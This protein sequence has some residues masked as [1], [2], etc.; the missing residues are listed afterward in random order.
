MAKLR[1]LKLSYHN[2]GKEKG[3]LLFKVQGFEVPL[4]VYIAIKKVSPI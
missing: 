1:N 2:N 4:W 3:K